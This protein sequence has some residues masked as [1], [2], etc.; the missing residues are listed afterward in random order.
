MYVITSVR[1][2][3][4]EEFRGLYLSRTTEAAKRMFSDA[5]LS[6]EDTVIRQHPEDFYLAHVG[7][8]DEETGEVSDT[9][10]A[11][12]DLHTNLIEADVLLTQHRIRQTIKADH[13]QLDLED[14]IAQDGIVQRTSGSFE[15]A[16]ADIP[17][18]HWL[19]KDTEQK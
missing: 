6:G 4:T 12:P 7:F 10:L 9:G 8:F 17:T 18:P 2:R 11:G 19:N 14:A 5:L 13:S 1:D 3:K 15:R 16:T